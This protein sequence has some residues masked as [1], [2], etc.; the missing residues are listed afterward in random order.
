MY[1]KEKLGVSRT[2][3]QKG[4]VLMISKGIGRTNQG[5]IGEQCLMMILCW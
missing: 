4:E 5:I 2:E 3:D 1:N